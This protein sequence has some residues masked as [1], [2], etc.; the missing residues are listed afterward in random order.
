MSV[1]ISLK[2]IP[3]GAID[4]ISSIGSDNGLLLIGDKPLSE[5]VVA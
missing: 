5:P 2:F 1:D 3:K 4:D